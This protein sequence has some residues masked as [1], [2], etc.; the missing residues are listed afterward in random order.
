[1]DHRR[2]A[3]DE[4]LLERFRREQEANRR[5]R[6]QP[7]DTGKPLEPGGGEDDSGGVDGLVE[8]VTRVEVRLDAVEHRL[9]SI[10]GRMGR[11]ETRFEAP[12]TEFD[13]RLRAVE[14]SVSAV[15][16]KLDLLT[17]QIVAKLPSRWQM[18]AVTGATVALLAGL[19]AAARWLGTRGWL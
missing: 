1:M 19:W 6:E 2:I 12:M 11:L 16:A 3:V 13:G 17:S 7:S 18:P 8:R 14:Q 4:S 5:L 15:S 9:G 10:E